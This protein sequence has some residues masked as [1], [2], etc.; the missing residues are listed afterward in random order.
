M[1]P[2]SVRDISL[3]IINIRSGASSTCYIEVNLGDLRPDL[4]MISNLN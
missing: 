4:S 2:R 3:K 1:L